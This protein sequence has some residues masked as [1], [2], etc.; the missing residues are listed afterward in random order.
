MSIEV[1]PISQPEWTPLTHPDARRVASRGLLRLDHL[2]LAMLRFEPH[3]TIHAHHADFDIE[4]ICL[5]GEGFTSI[6]TEQAA[7]RAGE[8]VRWPASIS[9]RLWTTENPMVTLMVEHLKT[10]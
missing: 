8:R 6:G 5:E 4:V 7:L 1:L 2:A 3:G 10:R 9:H